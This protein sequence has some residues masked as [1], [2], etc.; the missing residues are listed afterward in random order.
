MSVT[1]N[2]NIT[3]PTPSVTPGPTWADEINTG[4]DVV[5][6]HDHTS[7]N[8]VPIPTAGLALDADLSLN[9]NSLLEV[10]S[11]QMADQV[12]TLGP[13]NVDATYA[14]N[15]D[16]WFNNGAGT[17]VQITTGNQVN[18]SSTALVPSGVI[19]PYGGTSAPTGFLLC[20][21]T[22]VSRTTYSALFL[23]IGTTFGNGDG[24]TTFN[25]PNMKGRVPVGAGTYTDPVLGS[26]TRTLGTSAGEASHVQ[27]L[28]EM[29]THDHGGGAHTHQTVKLVS[30]SIGLTNTNSVAQ[31]RSLGDAADYNL[32][33]DNT[34][35]ANAGITS[36][37]ANIGYAGLSDPA[38]VMQPYVVTNYIIKY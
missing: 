6:S 27:T 32:V 28:S 34:A 19:W 5:D 22:A 15:G 20:D 13:S 7:G 21:G 12:T 17:P 36:S 31:A 35:G 1:P 33:S 9:Q 37:T 2:M 30:S 23:T 3:L 25:L 24:S 11:T 14:V 18:V 8:G 4:F 16:L 26:V 29:A 38:N 10:K